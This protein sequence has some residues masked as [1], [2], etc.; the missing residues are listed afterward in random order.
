MNG[1]A[2]I[3]ERHEFRLD[4]TGPALPAR[5]GLYGA[6]ESLCRGPDGIIERRY[7]GPAIGVVHSAPFSYRTETG[8]AMAVPGTI[9]FGN[10]GEHF[11]CRQ[12]D[13]AHNHRS[14]V[15]LDPALV[16]EAADAAGQ[17]SAAFRLA[18]ISPGPRS[19]PLHAGILRL[20]RSE[21]VQE[22]LV[23]ALVA[24][25]FGLDADCAAPP[26]SSRDSRAVLDVVRF[27]EECFADPHS[28]PDL[29]ARAG[30]S[31]F[32]FL[33]LFR[34]LTGTSPNR[35]LIGLRL[36]ACAEALQASAA[37]ITEVA[38]DAG[39]NDISHFNHLFRRAFAMSPGEW[40][41][42]GR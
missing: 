6:G 15:A 12:F 13:R 32:H 27:L 37:P 14:V 36:R 29:A 17:S 23:L 8:E 20:V 38:L 4:A 28:L 16:E 26:P 34:D 18:A 21:R 24:A 7:Q 30:L 2:S 5:G 31:R 25:A 40:R 39:F 1:H 35:F 9:L 19:A 33:R 3:S 22:D 42:L 11:I 10:A 41:R